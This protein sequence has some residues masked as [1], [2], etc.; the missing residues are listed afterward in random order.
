MTVENTSY[1]V[2]ALLRLR[3]VT[4]GDPGTLP[5]VLGYFQ[6]INVTPRRVVAEVTTGSQLHVHVDLFGLSEER[7]SLL[8][9]KIGQL[10]AV[11]NAYWHPV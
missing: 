1:S 5:R 7:L 8:T 4:D 3:I 10:P 2:A 11:L 9:A 6:N